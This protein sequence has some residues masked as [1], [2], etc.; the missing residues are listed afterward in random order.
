MP[1]QLLKDSRNVQWLQVKEIEA[2]HTSSGYIYI[3]QEIKNLP[4]HEVN[5]SQVYSPIYDIDKVFQDLNITNLVQAEAIKLPISKQLF[6]VRDCIVK[7]I[8]KSN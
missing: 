5:A 2:I 3:I 1:S 4:A 6:F 7:P 8:E